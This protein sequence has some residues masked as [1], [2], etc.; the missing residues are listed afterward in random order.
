MLRKL[1]HKR[2]GHP[3]AALMGPPDAS[4]WYCRSCGASN[5]GPRQGPPPA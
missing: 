3:K 5:T 4:S 1:W 2:F